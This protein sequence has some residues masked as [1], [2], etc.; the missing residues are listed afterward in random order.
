MQVLNQYDGTT[1]G[2]LFQQRVELFDSDF[3]DQG[4]K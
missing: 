3:T 2:D 1:F 4:A